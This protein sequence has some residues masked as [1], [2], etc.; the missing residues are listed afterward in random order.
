[1]DNANLLKAPGYELVNVNVHYKTD[2]VSDTF[3]S[4]NLFLEV[5]NVFDRTY[6]ASA[7]NIT[8]TVSAAGIP[9]TASTLASTATGSIYA[10]SPRTFVAGMKVAFK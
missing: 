3:K 9:D 6:V 5:R 4:L 1:M 7:N 8:N 10:G 2:L